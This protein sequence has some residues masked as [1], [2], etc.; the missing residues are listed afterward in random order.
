V[1]GAQTMTPSLPQQF[2]NLEANLR[3]VRDTGIIR[4]GVR[5]LEIGSGTGAMLHAL[6]EQGS[7]AHG[8]EIRQDLIDEAQRHFGPLPIER[9]FGTTL[10]FPDDSRGRCSFDATIPDTDAHLRGW[11]VPSAP[12]LR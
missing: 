3:F 6:I 2:G 10:P 1:D 4:P 11:R 7:D 12:R 9:V 5:L 8:V